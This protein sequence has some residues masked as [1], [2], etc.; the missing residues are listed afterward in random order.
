MEEEAPGEIKYIIN[1][2]IFTK[3][4]FIIDV[5]ISLTTNLEHIHPI[6]LFPT[7][8]TFL[9]MS[10]AF[11]QFITTEIFFNEILAKGASKNGFHV[12]F[13]P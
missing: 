11:T 1:L 2:Y 6:E 12:M 3:H 8:T 7:L 4:T 5:K 10:C 9:C 13:E